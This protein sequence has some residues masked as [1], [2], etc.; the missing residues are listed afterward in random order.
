MGDKYLGF[1]EFGTPPEIFWDT[2]P[3]V[4][5]GMPKIGPATSKGKWRHRTSSHAH[6]ATETE[7][8]EALKDGSTRVSK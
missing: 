6:E 1:C 3:H 8:T 4:T 7:G 2:T 5:P